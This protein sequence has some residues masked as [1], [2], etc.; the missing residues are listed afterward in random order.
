MTSRERV[1][2]V[3]D[4]RIPDRVPIHDG[5]WDEALERWTRE[6]LPQD[7]ASDKDDSLG[8][9]FD[10]EIRLIRINDSYLFEEKV[11]E[12]D[13]R[14]VTMLNKNGGV[15]K[16]IRGRTTTPG[17]LSF[18]APSREKWMELKGR[19]ESVEG[20][21]PRDLGRR[22]RNFRNGDR[23]VMACVH[24]P[25]E[26]SW[27]KVG[28]TFLLESMKTQPDLV[29]D[30]FGTMADLNIAACQHLFEQGYEVDGAWIWGDIAYSRGTLFSPKMYLEILYPYHKRLI[31][32]FAERG[33]PVVYHSDGDIRAVIPHLIDAGVTCI[34]PLESKAGMDLFEL[35]REYGRHL[36]FM[37]NV[38]FE[39]IALGH[40]EAEEE[41]RTKVG[42]G[43][44]GGGYIYHADHSVPPSISLDDYR[45]VLDLVRQYG[46]YG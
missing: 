37:G 7:V 3:F 23:F 45:H 18:A 19:L 22:Y 46:Q 9:Y 34:Q 33:L 20:R 27:S 15:M 1:A 39:R 6:G 38:D 5:Y 21:L 28:P 36:V 44:E 31:G 40:R 30:I 25:Y 42:L 14:Y 32:F 8:E 16:Y 12:E 41:I 11:L 2:A 29:H 26:G 24:D 35:K 17:L 10:T 4:R 43:K 13:D